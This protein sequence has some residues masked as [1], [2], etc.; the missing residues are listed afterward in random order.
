MLPSLPVM[1]TENGFPQAILGINADN[2]TQHR[3]NKRPSTVYSL[4]SKTLLSGSISLN[5]PSPTHVLSVRT[6]SWTPKPKAIGDGSE[7]KRLRETDKAWVYG[8]HGHWYR[9]KDWVG[10]T[11]EEQG[12]SQHMGLLWLMAAEK[13]G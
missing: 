10:I 4:R 1:F 7:I 8:K 11:R 6:A 2:D 5:S 12:S 9:G 13:G 3:E